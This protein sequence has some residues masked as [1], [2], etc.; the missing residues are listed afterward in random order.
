MKIKGNFIP[1]IFHSIMWPV[2][3]FLHGFNYGI[4]AGVSMGLASIVIIMLV[5]WNGSLLEATR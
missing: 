2:I 1:A 4:L 5:W 3:T